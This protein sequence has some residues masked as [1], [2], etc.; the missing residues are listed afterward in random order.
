MPWKW[1]TN[2][3]G[4]ESEAIFHQK[5]TPYQFQGMSERTLDFEAGE[6]IGFDFSA[7]AAVEEAGQFF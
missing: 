5:N 3:D 6:D 7:V 1:A 4:E 2:R